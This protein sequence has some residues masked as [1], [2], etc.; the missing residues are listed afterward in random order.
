MVNLGTFVRPRNMTP[1][2]GFSFLVPESRMSESIS[3]PF[4]PYVTLTAKISRYFAH[5]SSVTPFTVS[6]SPIRHPIRISKRPRFSLRRP[7]RP[8]VWAAQRQRPIR[9]LWFCFVRT[10]DFLLLRFII[11]LFFFRLLFSFRSILR[12]VLL[13][14]FLRCW[15]VLDLYFFIF[16]CLFLRRPFLWIAFWLWFTRSRFWF[17]TMIAFWSFVLRFRSMPTSSTSTS[18]TAPRST[19]FTFFR[20]ASAFG[21]GSSPWSTG[22]SWS[23]SW[24]SSRTTAGSAENFATNYSFARMRSRSGSGPR[25]PSTVVVLVVISFR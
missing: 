3:A 10:F 22:R 11:F 24:I 19:P 20:F 1:E 15:M 12:F 13:F 9:F 23:R 14:F 6:F 7:P 8:S 16:L 17:G 5:Y 4:V 21:L 18:T 25:V 2:V